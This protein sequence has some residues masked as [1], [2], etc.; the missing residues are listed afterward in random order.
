MTRKRVDA[1][2]SEIANALRRAGATVHDTHEV[3][4]GFPDLVVGFRGINYL[5]EVKVPGEKLNPV[6]SDWHVFWRG[7]SSVVST[8]GGALAVIGATR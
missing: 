8:V 1:N 7:R 4:R 2:Q 6:E 5:I 3:G